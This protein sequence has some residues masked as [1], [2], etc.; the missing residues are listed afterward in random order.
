MVG[1][2]VTLT[3]TLTLRP[4]PNPNPCPN[5]NP[6]PSQA[7]HAKQMAISEVGAPQQKEYLDASKEHAIALTLN[8]NPYP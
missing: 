5:A 6:S 7:E 2:R 8:P 1:V 4:N 3:L